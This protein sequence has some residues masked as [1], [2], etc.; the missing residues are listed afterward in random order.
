M[1]ATTMITTRLYVSIWFSYSHYPLF[2]LMPVTL[3]RTHILDFFPQP[4]SPVTD[5]VASDLPKVNPC[6]TIT[7]CF[8]VGPKQ[9]FMVSSFFRTAVLIPG[10]K[11]ATSGNYPAPEAH[12][13]EQNNFWL[14]EL[15]HFPQHAGYSG[16]LREG[17]S[18]RLYGHQFRVP[19]SPGTYQKHCRRSSPSGSAP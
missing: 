14:L 6:R 16:G 17:S 19:R 2:T 1:I 8:W 9:A 12:K 10:K 5:P 15:M 4:E 18:S 11:I 13:P 7:H 3:T